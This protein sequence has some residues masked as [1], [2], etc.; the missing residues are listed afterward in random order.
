MLEKLKRLGVE[1]AIYGI[2]TVLGR[3]LIFLLVP[4]YTHILPTGDYGVVAYLYAYIAFLNVIYGYGMES[5]FFKYAST[6][7]LGDRKQTFS[8]P[9]ASVLFTSFLFSLFIDFSASNIAGL[10]EIGS[11]NA[12]LIQLAAWI[13]F[14]DAISVIPFASLRL[15]RKPVRFALIRLINIIVNLTLNVV[16]L[17]H[18]HL[19]IIGIFMSGLVS[20]ALT[21]MLLLPTIFRN[22]SFEYLPLIHKELLKFGL[23]YLPSGLSW[24]VIQVIDRPIL[25]SLTD[26]S[27]VGIYQASYKLGIFM[28][29][30]VNMFDYA[31]RPF[32][33]SNAREQDAKA[34]FSRV[35]TYFAL[36][37]AVVVLIL[38]LFIED[39]V[40]VQFFGRSL[41]HPNYWGG[42]GIV[43]VILLA[44][45]FS[46]VYIIFTPGIYIEK[47]TYHLPYIVGIGAM[48]N[49]VANYLLIPVLGMMGAAYATLLSYLSM[50]VA[51]Y[52]VVQRFYHVEY[53]FD[54]VAKIAL[55]LAV[56]MILF[57]TG[58][59]FLTG[60]LF[61]LLK[62][63]LVLGFL[64]LM[65]LF[66]FF[67]TEEKDFFKTLLARGNS[68]VEPVK[69]E[70]E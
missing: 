11:G 67:E 62:F 12:I 23:P 3:F 26:E 24:M 58:K 57:Y 70:S 65:A 30:L 35:L 31:W 32:F 64:S 68:R 49:V 53:E 21:F 1:T 39:I 44:H 19:G 36:A 22:F 2:S 41:I 6:L 10:L 18:F 69:P 59:Y 17:L 51:L 9:F 13:L 63:V 54:R 52:V 55:S 34:M 25:R 15:D 28:L 40:K 47:K 50:A 29:L 48:I 14:F 43:P 46:G 42:L 5:A 4:F 20:S 38:S 33:L 16:L 37:S 27:T 45:V 8:T 60:Q 61:F 56:A 66:K 7:E